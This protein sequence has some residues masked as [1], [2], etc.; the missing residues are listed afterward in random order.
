MRAT[1]PGSRMSRGLT[2]EAE[3]ISKF[4]NTKVITKRP[5]ARTEQM[6]ARDS[7][8]VS[9]SSGCSVVVAP[10]DPALGSTADS[11]STA[12]VF[13]HRSVGWHS[14]LVCRVRLNSVY[15]GRSQDRQDNGRFS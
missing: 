10:G 6:E 7:R 4:W 13:I 1:R 3:G 5:M 15:R 9:C 8:A 2:I 14:V 11:G 12:L